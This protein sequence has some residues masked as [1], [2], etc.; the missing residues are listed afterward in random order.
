MWDDSIPEIILRW[1]LFKRFLENGFNAIPVP[2]GGFVNIDP[3][4]DHGESQ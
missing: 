4:R 1:P 2:C 3:V